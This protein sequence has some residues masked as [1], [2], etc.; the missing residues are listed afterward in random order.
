MKTKIIKSSLTVI[1]L[2]LLMTSCKKKVDKDY[3]PEFIGNW[4][5]WGNYP[6]EYSLVIDSNSN[7]SFDYNNA[8]GEE[9]FI[10]GKA[11]ANDKHF[12]I[13]RFASFKI[14]DYPHKIDTATTTILDPFTWKKCNWEMTLDHP[15][16]YGKGGTCYK[17]VY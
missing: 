2:C 15:L 16:F 12:K 5:G 13:G 6:I 1:L 7:A 11:R 8:N 10:R 17:A 9:H 4:T 14:V 3:R